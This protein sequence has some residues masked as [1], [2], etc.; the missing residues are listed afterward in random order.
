MLAVHSWTRL[1]GYVGPRDV[2]RTTISIPARYVLPVHIPD[3]TI[4]PISVDTF[5]ISCT[6][7]TIPRTRARCGVLPS[8]RRA[9]II[10]VL[11]LSV[12]RSGVTSIRSFVTAEKVLE[13]AWLVYFIDALRSVPRSRYESHVI[14]TCRF[15]S[16]SVSVIYCVPFPSL[17]RKNASTMFNR[18]SY[19]PTTTTVRSGWPFGNSNLIANVASGNGAKSGASD[20][21]HPRQSLHTARFFHAFP[22][23]YQAQQG[24]ND[25]SRILVRRGTKKGWSPPIRSIDSTAPANVGARVT[26]LSDRSA[27]EN[28]IHRINVQLK[29]T[30]RD[31]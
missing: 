22:N 23:E 28:A 24:V 15:G 17:V 4:R 26:S 14:D 13:S 1:R 21:R 18:T 5:A 2:V 10:Y 12:S 20:K 19:A 25:A 9:E 16:F 31:G 6:S 11:S 29:R 30:Q 8:W 7:C 3:S 27:C